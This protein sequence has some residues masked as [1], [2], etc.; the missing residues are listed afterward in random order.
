MA[1]RWPSASRLARDARMACAPARDAPVV[2]TPEA[3]CPTHASP[4][5]RGPCLLHG[6]LRAQATYTELVL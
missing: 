4:H 5:A 3:P 6:S 1:Q 2:R